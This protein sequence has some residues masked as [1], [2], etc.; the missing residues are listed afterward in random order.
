VPLSSFQSRVLRLLAANRN[1]ES[2]VA[3]EAPLA[4]EGSRFSKDIDLFHDREI[5]MQ[6][7][8]T[9][10][11]AV[12]EQ[13]GFAI[14]WIRR[15]PTI[16]AAIVRAGDD[17]TLLEWV[18]DSAYRFFPALQ[19]DLF[20]YVLHPAD[21]ATNKALAA[22]GRREPRDIVDLL[23]IHKNYLPLG[24]VVWAACAKDPGF[25]PEGL[26]AEIRRNARYHQADY[27]RLENETSIDAAATSRAL[28]AAL[29]E[30]D[31]FVRSMSAGKEGLLFLDSAGRPVRPDPA[32][33]DDYATHDGQE[34][35]HW[36]SSPDISR[37]MLERYNQKPDA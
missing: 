33:L 2:F 37:A 1:P 8:V 30:A 26:I 15:F 4:R 9:A 36:P 18:V 22:A 6:E 23:D 21:I 12:L 25:S 29:D 32:R 3:G 17:G 7:A 24:A 27:D 20:G 16:F 14:E 10:D 13:Q 5:A 34:R 19:D 31:A 28:R 11:T 35:G